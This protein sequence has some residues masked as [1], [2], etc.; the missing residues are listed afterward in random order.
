MVTFLVFIRPQI[1][2]NTGF[3]RQLIAYE[4][5]LFDGMAT[6]K[7]VFKE[8]LA[9]EIPDVYETEYEAMELFYKKY[10]HLRLR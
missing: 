9:V 1:R 10:Q 8:S 2:P 3:F 4:E 6:V 7:M 5:S